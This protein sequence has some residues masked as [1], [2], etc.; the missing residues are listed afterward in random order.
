MFNVSIID[1]NLS[2]LGH[3]ENNSEVG[4][5]ELNVKLKI[6]ITDKSLTSFINFQHS[7]QKVKPPVMSIS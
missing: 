7:S 4:I 2:P 5:I 1:S 3:D 6:N